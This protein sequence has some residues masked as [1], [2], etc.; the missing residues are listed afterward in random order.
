MAATCNST[1]PNLICGSADCPAQLACLTNK[2]FP[3]IIIALEIFVGTVVLFMAIWAGFQYM[4]SRSD[5]KAIESAH[6]TLLYAAFG[7]CLVLFS[8]L[9]LNVIG[10][11]TGVTCIEP[12]NY[13]Q[14]GILF[15]C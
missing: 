4:T 2:I 12:Q 7:G 14:N 1:D 5:K 15:A 11:A 8:F 6:K 9:I 13:F 3:N 10:E